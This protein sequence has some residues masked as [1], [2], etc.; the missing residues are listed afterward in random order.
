MNAKFGWCKAGAGATILP[1]PTDLSPDDSTRWGAVLERNPAAD[2]RFVYAVASTRVYCRPSCPSRRPHRRQV[3]FYPSSSAAEAAGYRACRRCHPRE[4]DPPATRRVKAAQSYLETHLQ[5][6][7]TLER[8]GQAVGMSPYHLLR[9]FKRVTGTTPRKFVEARRMEQMK[10]SLKEGRSVTRAMFEAGYSSIS[11]AYQQTSARM[12]MTPAEYRR[13]GKD[14]SIRYTIHHTDLG[15]LLVAATGKGLCDVALG[16]SPAPLEE[17]LQREYPAAQVTRCDGELREWTRAVV[18]RL[19]GTADAPLPL[20]V[21]G[22]AFQRR[23][24]DALLR[25]PRGSTRSYSEIARAV[26]QPSAARA[27]ARACAGNR[28]AV[29]VPCHRVVRED[30]GLG[31]YRWGI[32]RKRALLER[33][34]SS[35]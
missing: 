14:V 16:D 28:V 23:V 6:T 27:V 13:G 22:T 21:P 5:E 18:E 3:R 11:R 4:A 15:V 30:G 32:E 31:G 8:L 1:M 33:E 2:G 26:G 29:V 34:R 25:I 17:A 19:A 12:G 35:P 10:S 9:T 20:D 7:I 24:W